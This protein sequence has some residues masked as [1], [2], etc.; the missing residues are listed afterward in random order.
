VG[1]QRRGGGARAR[2]AWRPRAANP[3]AGARRRAPAAGLFAGA[4]LGISAIDQ[5]AL[6]DMDPSGEVRRAGAQSGARRAAAGGARARTLSPPVRLP[7]PSLAAPPQLA[8]KRFAA[9]YRRAAPLQGGLALVGG[10]AAL[11]A[12]AHGGHCSRV[13]WGASGAALLAVWPW[14]LFAMVGRRAG[15]QAGRLQGWRRARARSKRLPCE[16]APR[17]PPPSPAPRPCPRTPFPDAH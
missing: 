17:P 7:L 5:P 6:I 11:V 9:M 13:L 15:R 12:A 3:S 2:P 8:A 10:A 4:A 14:T 1:A 16:R